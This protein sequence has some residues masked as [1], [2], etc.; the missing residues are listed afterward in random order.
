MVNK[1]GN[2]SI[3]LKKHSLTTKVSY[4]TFHFIIKVCFCSL[5]WAAAWAQENAGEES[6]QIE[7]SEEQAF[8]DE[9]KTGEDEEH[10][11]ESEGFI[12]IVDSQYVELYRFPGRGF[13]RFHA[14]EKGEKIRL[15]KRRGDWYKIQ[16]IEDKIG[17]AHRRQL[18]SIKDLEG[19]HLDFAVPKWGETE[20]RWS[21][22]LLGGILEQSP[23]YTLYA[24]YRFTPNISTEIR[25]SQTFGDASN[26]KQVHL[27]LLH[28]PFPQWRA[29]PFFSLGAGSVKVYPDTILVK[30]EDQVDNAVSVGTG[31]RFY[32]THNVIFRAEYHSH[33]ILTTRETNEEVEEWK[34]GLSVLF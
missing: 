5:I 14:V 17:W 34:A 11:E 24:G 2:I 21:L 16:T 3:A 10:F 12:A 25:Y 13:P 29:S 4:R 32:L 19:Y 7:P 28:Q 1:Q 33:I 23:S 27:M 20:N 31:L 15:F 26:V 30:V 9:P 18:F 8:V 6:V 22:G